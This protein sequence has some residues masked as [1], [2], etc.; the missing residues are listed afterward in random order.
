MTSNKAVFLDRD[1]TIIKDTNYIKDAK[2]VELLEDSLKAI[3]LLVKNNFL[4]FIVTNQSGVG[5]G[6]MTKDDVNQVNKKVLSLIGEDKIEKILIC[7]HKPEDNCQCRKP[8]TG[9]I[10]PIIKKY[11]IKKFYSIG[12]KDSDKKLAENL[13]QKGIKL[14]EKNIN[15]LL[16]AVKFIL[17]QKS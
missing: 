5:R 16:D 10:E 4:I 11:N 14:G 9:L 3:N 1:G 2:K 8:K 7:Y 17:K 15:T 12:D 13:N 6:L